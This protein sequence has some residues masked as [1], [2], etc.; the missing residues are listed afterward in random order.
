MELKAREESGVVIIYPIGEMDLYNAP[1]LK[2]KIQEF[3]VENKKNFIINLEHISYTDSS[4]I[5]A[6]IASLTQL[7]KQGGML[8]LSNTKASIHKI[9]V[10]TELTSFFQMFN[11]EEEAL[12]SYR[13][14]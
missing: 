8:K 12:S 11:T 7:R 2:E 14:S 3:L 13:N 5:G 4:G 9:F 6:L 10:L 1:N